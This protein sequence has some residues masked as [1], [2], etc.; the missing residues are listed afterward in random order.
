[1]LLYETI[2][3]LYLIVH[4]V[5][6]DGLHELPGVDS[7][8]VA[9]CHRGVVDLGNMLKEN[10]KLFSRVQINPYLRK[11]LDPGDA[12]LV[13]PLGDG[14]EDDER[15]VGGRPGD[16]ADPEEALE[17][18]RRGHEVD[19]AV[20]GGRLAVGPRVSRRDGPV[21]FRRYVLYSHK[22]NIAYPAPS[23]AFFSFAISF[24]AC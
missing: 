10:V 16:H 3:S 18:A 9:Q 5:V 14:A 23:F 13:V 1:M 11:G 17:E 21:E 19:P 12:R 7:G 22:Y 2:I 4:E 6:E 15:R 20:Q 24:G 8:R